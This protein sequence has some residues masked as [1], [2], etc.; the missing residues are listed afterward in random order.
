MIRNFIFGVYLLISDLL[1]ESLKTN[2]NLLK[3]QPFYNIVSL[4]KSHSFY[5][6]QL[7]RYYKEYT[8]ATQPKTCSWW[9]S[10][11]NICI[12][13]FLDAQ[14][15][16][17]WSIWKANIYIFLFIFVRNFFFPKRKKLLSSG[18]LNNFLQ[19]DRCLG[20]AKYV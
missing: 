7:T 18:G 3:Y 10:E 4:K 17:F 5:E 13:P 19:A 14:E 8:L 20:L 1:V 2:E 12:V 15:L 9:S 11:K 6:P 16:H